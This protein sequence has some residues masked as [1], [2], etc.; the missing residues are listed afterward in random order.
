MSSAFRHDL[1]RWVAPGE[2]ADAS[3]LTARTVLRLLWQHLPVRATALFRLACWLKRRRI[4]FFPGALQRLNFGLFGIEIPSGAEIGGGL[5]I[6]HPVGTVIAPRRIGRN[7]SI[8]AAVTIGMRTER[9]FPDIG[10]DVFIG[11]GARV[12][13]GIRIG[14]RAIIGANAVVIQDVP[15]GATAVGVPARII[16]ARQA[17]DLDG[18]EPGEE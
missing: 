14:D 8:I 13:G 9:E 4:P 18:S 17:L 16:P 1:L 11:A 10:D 6:A 7:C 3:A 12:L 15:D 5:Y 2:M